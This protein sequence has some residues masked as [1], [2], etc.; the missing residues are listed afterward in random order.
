MNITI[1]VELQGS[2]T[3]Y[4]EKRLLTLSCLSICLSVRIEELGCHWTNCHEIWYL[5]IFR[6]F[7]VKIQVL[8]KCDK[9]HGYITWRQYILLIITRSILRM[10]NVSEKVVEKK[11]I[12]LSKDVFRKSH[13]WRDMENIWELGRPQITIW[14]MRIACWIP[15]AA[16]IFSEYE[17]LFAFP[18]QKMVVRTCF[19]DRS[20]LFVHCL[21]CFVLRYTKIYL[22]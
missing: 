16:N 19:N 15:K 3:A 18:L 5:S 1:K 21:S 14:H 11:Q 17:T 13:R 9:N 2:M 7:V 10:K 6:K 12:L 8:L 20:T 4:F 22:N